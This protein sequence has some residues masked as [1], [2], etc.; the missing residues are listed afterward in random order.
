LH[1]YKW[2]TDL[3]ACWDEILDVPTFRAYNLLAAATSLVGNDS[4]KERAFQAALPTALERSPVDEVLG[5]E[6]DGY[7]IRL[8]ELKARIPNGRL[9]AALGVNQDG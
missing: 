1:R 4:P 9:R 3:G 8:R 6:M 5:P 7:Q 2:I